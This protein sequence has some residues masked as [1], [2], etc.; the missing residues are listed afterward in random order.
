MVFSLGYADAIFL[1]KSGKLTF[2]GG[3]YSS[4]TGGKI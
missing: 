1:M 3:S 4:F 2:F